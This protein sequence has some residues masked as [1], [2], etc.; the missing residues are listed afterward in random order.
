[1]TNLDVMETDPAE[2]MEKE[3]STWVKYAK[4]FEGTADGDT[5]AGDSKLIKQI[6]G[7][8][9]WLSGIPGIDEATALSTAV[10]YIESD[11]CDLIVFDSTTTGHTLK[12]L[13]L[14]DIL[15]K[16]IEKL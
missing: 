8:Q 10:T 5:N 13:A 1:M 14:P 4:E 9:E 7:F 6:S 2:R 11:R 15:E 3:F 12:L 16:G